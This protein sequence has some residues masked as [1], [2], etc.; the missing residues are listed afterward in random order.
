MYRGYRGYRGYRVYRVYRGYRGYSLPAT[1]EKGSIPLPDKQQDFVMQYILCVCISTGPRTA[2]KDM[3]WS[4]WWSALCSSIYYLRLSSRL[5][6][7][8]T[9]SSCFCRPHYRP[10]HSCIAYSL[11][12]YC[13]RLPEEQR[14]Y[15][16]IGNRI[17]QYSGDIVV[18]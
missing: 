10:L 14:L 18:I 6:I 12:L 9:A 15:V 13:I 5:P 2:G 11:R 7:R 4:L 1:I 8:S 3:Q 16:F 17:L